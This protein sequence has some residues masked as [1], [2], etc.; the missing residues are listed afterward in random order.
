M[1]VV[2]TSTHRL[3]ATHTPTVLSVLIISYFTANIYQLTM[4]QSCSGEERAA[5]IRAQEAAREAEL[6]HSRPIVVPT[7]HTRHVTTT[8]PT[9]HTTDTLSGDTTT[10]YDTDSAEHSVTREMPLYVTTSPA[11]TPVFAPLPLLITA[12]A[13]PPPSP[14]NLPNMTNP[15]EIDRVFDVSVADMVPRQSV[16]TG[17]LSTE[18]RFFKAVESIAVTPLSFGDQRFNSFTPVTFTTAAVPSLPTSTSF[19]HPRINWRP[20]FSTEIAALEGDSSSS[21]QMNECDRATRRKE[22]KQNK[23]KSRLSSINTEMR[24]S[25][26]GSMSAIS[27]ASSRHVHSSNISAFPSASSSAGNYSSFAFDMEGEPHSSDAFDRLPSA[28]SQSGDEAAAAA[29]GVT[30]NT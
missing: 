19:S 9:P 24:R 8:H 30:S 27:P 21:T 25:R 11:Y 6:N 2:V 29:E 13:A 10:T 20:A 15:A 14:E 28:S 16:H 22:R 4:G 3:S 17:P 18:Q 5:Y 12:P 7:A 26:A 23:S 1:S